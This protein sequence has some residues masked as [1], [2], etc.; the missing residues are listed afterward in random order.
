MDPLHCFV[1]EEAWEELEFEV[2]LDSGSVVHVCAL[3]DCPGYRLGESPGSRRK[4][5]FMM[6]DGG[7]IPNL[8]ETQLN[9]SDGGGT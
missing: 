5:V 2:A 4:Q 1:N 8:G 9:L 7:E 3:S 6:G